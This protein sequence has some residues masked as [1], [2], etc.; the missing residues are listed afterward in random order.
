MV[1]IGAKLDGVVRAHRKDCDRGFSD[2]AHYSIL[3]SEWPKLK[4][5]LQS[6]L[7]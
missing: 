6:K 3:N 7:W 4:K 2:T 5:R 1:K